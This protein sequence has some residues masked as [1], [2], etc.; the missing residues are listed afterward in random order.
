MINFALFIDIILRGI[1]IKK[2]VKIKD[3]FV[4]FLKNLNLFSI[5]VDIDEFIGIIV[6]KFGRQKWSYS[7][8]CFYFIRHNNDNFIMGQQISKIS[9]INKKS[10]PVKHLTQ[11]Q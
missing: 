9:Q 11:F 8:C 4:I 7:N 3:S 6:F 2:I 5:L 1:L 10:S